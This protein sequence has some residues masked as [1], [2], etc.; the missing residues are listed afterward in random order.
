MKTSLNIEKLTKFDLVKGCNNMITMRNRLLGARK[1]SGVKL[2][3]LNTMNKKSR[4]FVEELFQ[5]EWDWLRE[6]IRYYYRNHMP[7]PFDF[8][9][10]A[11][12]DLHKDVNDEQEKV[13]QNYKSLLDTREAYLY[14][15]IC[16]HIKASGLLFDET[17]ITIDDIEVKIN[18]DENLNIS[19][20]N[21]FGGVINYYHKYSWTETDKEPVDEINFGTI[22][23]FNL[24][25]RRGRQQMFLMGVIC[26]LRDKTIRKK[27]AEV[28]EELRSINN[29]RYRVNN[30][31]N[32]KLVN[33]IDDIL[34]PF[35]DN[36][37]IH[38]T[39]NVK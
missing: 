11:L 7:L 9:T 39:G 30:R 33:G 14:E 5:H 6:E 35:I 21:C 17:E 18:S 37:A 22:G 27:I 23:A 24:D 1:I 15:E 3:S 36:I 13:W 20:K 31:L 16:N 2:Y 34:A 8:D 25:S 12:D 38:G 32:T 29:N 19:L 4:E 26:S 28:M 10:K